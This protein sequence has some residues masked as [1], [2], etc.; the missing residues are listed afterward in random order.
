ML[1]NGP[2][3]IIM[4]AINIHWLLILHATAAL[5]K[6][7]EAIDS[8]DIGLA[9]DQDNAQILSIKQK[10][11]EELLKLEKIQNALAEKRSEAVIL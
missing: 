4:Y 7:K 11:A 9:I 1:Q 8:C 10:C 3:L 6:F 2:L 5:R